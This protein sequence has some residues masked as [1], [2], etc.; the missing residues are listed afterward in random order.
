MCVEIHCHDRQYDEDINE[1]GF[2]Y[3]L[4]IK[5]FVLTYGVMVK[6]AKEKECQNNKYSLDTLTAAASANINVLVN[7]EMLTAIS[8]EHND[9]KTDDCWRQLV[10]ARSEFERPIPFEIHNS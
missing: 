3:C 5:A 10:S 1:P 2:F 6:I 9:A 8:C 4:K 7:V